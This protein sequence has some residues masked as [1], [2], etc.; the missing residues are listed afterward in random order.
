MNHLRN[1]T[2]PFTAVRCAHSIQ[3][4]LLFHAQYVQL[5][6]QYSIHL[7]P[8]IHRSLACRANWIGQSQ[9]LHS[10]SIYH[11]G[12]KEPSTQMPL[13]T[14]W[15]MLWCWLRARDTLGKNWHNDADISISA[16]QRRITILYSYFFPLPASVEI[17]SLLDYGQYSIKVEHVPKQIKHE[18]SELP[19]G[20]FTFIFP[21]K[22][23]KAQIM[24][25]STTLSEKK[26]CKNSWPKI[27][28]YIYKLLWLL[29]QCRSVC[30]VDVEANWP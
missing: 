14:V 3:L 5:K 21:F 11:L 20:Q 8:F 28:N 29:W 18:M 30:V 2:M 16:T 7:N 27:S 22:T 24:T 25:D 13:G 19:L 15:L 26:H 9:L 10:Q 12:N 23:A 17:S 1:G 4:T 6:H